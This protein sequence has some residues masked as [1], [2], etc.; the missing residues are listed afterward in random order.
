MTI[1]NF[2]LK[3]IRIFILNN[4]KTNKVCIICFNIN[5]YL[6]IWTIVTQQTTIFYCSNPTTWLLT[7]V[8]SS[9]NNSS[10]IAHKIIHFF[11]YAII[12][13]C[14]KFCYFMCTRRVVFYSKR[15]F[16]NSKWFQ[17]FFVFFFIHND[18]CFIYLVKAG[19]AWL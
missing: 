5:V 11:V 15:I 14:L 4:R 18:S 7:E 17:L 13:H 6:F 16:W 8:S 2:V 1:E 9:T 12:Y 10:S 19:A 3:K